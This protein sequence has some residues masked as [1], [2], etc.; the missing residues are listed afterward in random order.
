MSLQVKITYLMEKYGVDWC[1][2]LEVLKLNN[3]DLM[4]A[5]GDI[6]YTGA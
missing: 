1:A 5:S 3:G 2:A 6:R 4:M